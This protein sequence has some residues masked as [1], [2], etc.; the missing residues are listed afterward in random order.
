MLAEFEL[1]PLWEIYESVSQAATSVGMKSELFPDG[2]GSKTIQSAVSETAKI[3]ATT[4][5]ME[6]VMAAIRVGDP[7]AVSPHSHDDRLLPR[8]Q[9]ELQQIM[10]KIGAGSE[11][12]V[13]SAVF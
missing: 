7:S 2:I 6:R 13:V 10:S 4:P 9:R 5:G 12:S 8:N 3:E 11:Y 1:G